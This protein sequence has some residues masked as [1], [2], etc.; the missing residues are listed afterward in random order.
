[1]NKLPPCLLSN[2]NC[3]LILILRNVRI[4]RTWITPKADLR[5]GVQNQWLWKKLVS[6]KCEN[7]CAESILVPPESDQTLPLESQEVPIWAGHCKTKRRKEE[8][9]EWNFLQMPQQCLSS[10]PFNPFKL[11]GSFS[12]SFTT[13]ETSTVKVSWLVQQTDVS[14]SEPSRKSD[15]TSKRIQ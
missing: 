3:I 9:N 5:C 11:K 15:N 6:Q 1:M 2:L 12:L 7:P 4:Y 14:P 10:C 8:G 13:C